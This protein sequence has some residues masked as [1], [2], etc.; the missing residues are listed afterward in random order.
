MA[1]LERL[2]VVLRPDHENEGKREV[3]HMHGLRMF[4]LGF[5]LRAGAVGRHT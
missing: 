2:G 1:K 4:G 5:G 3:M